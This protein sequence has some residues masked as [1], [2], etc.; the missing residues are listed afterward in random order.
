MTMNIYPTLN[1][2]FNSIKVRLEHSKVS[3]DSPKFDYFN[4]IKVRLE[5]IM[6]KVV[7]IPP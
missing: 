1:V 5:L 7:F 2:Y 3:S 4:S 6:A